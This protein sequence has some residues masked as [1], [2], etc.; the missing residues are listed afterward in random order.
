MQIEQHRIG[1]PFIRA[2]PQADQHANEHVDPED[3]HNIKPEQPAGQQD[4]AEDQDAGLG[5]RVAQRTG[6]GDRHGEADVLR[7]EQQPDLRRRQADVARRC[8]HQRVTDPQE[9]H[10]EE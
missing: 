9:Q 6:D 1:G 8:A 7:G 4:A 10:R 5:L 3:R 2:D